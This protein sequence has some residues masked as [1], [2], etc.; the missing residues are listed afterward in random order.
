RHLL[1][2]F[3]LLTFGLLVLHPVFDAQFVLVDDHE[4][5]SLTAPQG[6]PRSS[7]PR[8]DVRGMAFES[9]PSVGRFGP[10]YW[11]I[12]FG[13]IAALADD[14]R[15]WHALVFALGIVSASALYATASV[16]GTGL[17]LAWLPGAWLLAA[18]GVG[19]LG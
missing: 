4:I 1:A 12:R 10:L 13:G 17:L 3:A 16:L 14:A 18:P 5:L 7:A 9:D 19:S 15:A 8:L 2:I 6:S 11:T